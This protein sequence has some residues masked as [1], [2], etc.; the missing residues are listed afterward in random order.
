MEKP[1]T[2]FINNVK[3]LSF[4]KMNVL[5][6]SPKKQKFWVNKQ[7]LRTG[8]KQKHYVYLFTSSKD[9]HGSMVPATVRLAKEANKSE[10]E[11]ILVTD[12]AGSYYLEQQKVLIK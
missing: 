8:K 7:N 6:E 12:L 9:E 2:I 1:R 4:A 11:D 5:V 3:P 10:G